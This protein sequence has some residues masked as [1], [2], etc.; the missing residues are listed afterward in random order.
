LQQNEKETLQN[1]CIYTNPTKCNEILFLRLFLVH[2][3]QL[4]II[5][6]DI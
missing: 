5:T 3:S 2:V 4:H 1:T 6:V